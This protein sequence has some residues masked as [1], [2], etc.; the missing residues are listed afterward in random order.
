M[1]KYLQKLIQIKQ[2]NQQ[3]G[4][5]GLGVE[6]QQFLDWLIQT[7]NFEPSN[8]LIFDQ[9]LTSDKITKLAQKWNLKPDN[10]YLGENY[11]DKLLSQKDD[12]EWAFKSPGIW[13]LKPELETLRKSKGTE[14]I[15]S[16][17]VFF[18]EKFAHQTVAVT[19]SK[20]KTTTSSLLQHFFQ[21][22]SQS[23]PNFPKSFYCGNTTGVSPYRYWTELEQMN[24]DKFFVLETSS[25]QLQDLSFNKVS[26]DYGVITNYFIDHLD[27]HANK[28]EY[29]Y[30]KDQLFL[31]QNSKNRASLTGSNPSSENS[32]QFLVAGNNVKQNLLDRQKIIATDPKLAKFFEKIPDTEFWITDDL[33]LILQEIFETKQNLPGKHNWQNLATALTAF[34][35]IYLKFTKTKNPNLQQ[36]LAELKKNQQQLQVAIDSFKNVG[37]RLELV[38]A[39]KKSSFGLNFFDDGASTHPD[40]V[41]ASI[42]TLTEKSTD[43][44]ILFVTGKDKGGSWLPVWQALQ[45]N[46]HKIIKI[47]AFSE[48]GLRFSQEIKI[49]NSFNFVDLQSKIHYQNSFKDFL[50][51]DFQKSIQQILEQKLKSAK[52]N[53]NLCLSPGGSSFDEFENYLVRSEKW[54]LVCNNFASSFH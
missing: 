51:F 15:S 48:I 23:N 36:V 26:F 9:K 46:W 1:Q 43:N 29:W 30:S 6:I 19:G 41:A 7:V 39:I 34:G 21:N 18:V 24:N 52:I 3:I 20:G 8:I 5:I 2:Q 16:S 28:Y 27:Q 25:F 49:Q 54:K 32:N 13:S 4:L 35:L 14:F 44:L 11:L 38:C 37:M 53:L 12:L 10:F 22:F 45:K 17:L 33:I 47:Y 42:Q 31:S 40:S 50:N